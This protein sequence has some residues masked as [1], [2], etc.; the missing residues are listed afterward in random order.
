MTYFN[1][2]WRKFKNNWR[3]GSWIPQ[4]LMIHHNIMGPRNYFIPNID[5]RMFDCNN[6]ITWIF[7]MEQFFDLHQVPTMQKVTISSLYLEPN[8]FVQYQWLCDR[9]KESIISWSIFTEEL[10][11]YYGDINSNTFFNQLVNLKQK[12][13]LTDHIKQFQQLSLRVKNISED[14]LLDLFIGTLK[15][16]MGDSM[17]MGNTFW[18]N[19]AMKT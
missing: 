6:P 10:I 18:P 14:N 8:Q 19:L 12:G 7:Q 4:N 17:K 16:N 1:H 5:M 9:K 3:V 2:V 11:A 13:S 15:D